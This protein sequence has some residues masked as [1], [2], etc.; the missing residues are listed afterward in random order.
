MTPPR[1]RALAPT[2]PLATFVLGVAAPLT[3][4]LLRDDPQALTPAGFALEQAV[5]VDATPEEAWEAFTGDVSGWWDHSFSGDPHRLTIEPRPGGGFVEVFDASGDGA[6]HA[7]VTMA[8]RAEELQ[9]RGPLGFA[10]EGLN[11][12]M[13]H[14]VRFEAVEGGTR[15][16]VAVRGIG[17]VPEGSPP[18]VQRVWRHFL[19]ERF[20]PYVE[21]TLG[22]GR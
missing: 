14:R 15:V 16:S 21:G 3:L 22:Q 9:F 10:K 4:T 13:A 6:L 11:L 1:P 5:V 20:K 17:E 19:E 7:T 12:Q 18:I 8:K 2:L